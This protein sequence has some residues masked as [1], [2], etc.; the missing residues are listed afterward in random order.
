MVV[1]GSIDGYTRGEMEDIITD[2]GGRA[3]AS[4]SKKTDLVIYGQKAGSKLTKAQQLGVETI[5]TQDFLK[6]V[7]M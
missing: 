6:L 7:G 1:T 4:V 2:A 5:T 3:S